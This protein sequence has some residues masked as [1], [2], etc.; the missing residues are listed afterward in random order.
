MENSNYKIG[1]PAFNK[2][3][4]LVIVDFLSVLYAYFKLKSLNIKIRKTYTKIPKKG[5]IL[6][7]AHHEEWVDPLVIK[8]N[9]ERRLNWVAASINFMDDVFGDNIFWRRF[10]KKLLDKIGIISIDK[11]NPKR[12]IGFVEYITYL[13]KIG[14]AVI[15]FPEGN[16]RSE[17]NNKRLGKVKDGVIRIAQFAQKKLNRKI[18]IYP[19]GLEYRKKNKLTEAYVRIEGPFFVDNKENSTK[20]MQRLMKKIAILSNIKNV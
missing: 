13:L 14:E 15:I 3:F 12:N 5:G 1:K 6:I 7:A 8:K 17:R 18:P 10:F 16:F 19:I 2:L 9:I 11:K 20:A 4:I